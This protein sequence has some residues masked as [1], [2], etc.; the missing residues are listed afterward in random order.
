MSLRL[1]FA[2]RTA[3]IKMYTI[4]MCPIVYVWIE[5]ALGLSND[6]FPVL[7]FLMLVVWFLPG[8]LV[9]MLTR[10]DISFV[11]C[12]IGKSLSGSCFANCAFVAKRVLT[13]GLLLDVI[14]TRFSIVTFNVLSCVSNSIAEFA[15]NPAFSAVNLYMSLCS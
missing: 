6:N 9:M 8:I 14:A 13:W 15:P 3:V 1:V 12:V 5:C 2:V 7:V 10:F 4:T 11:N